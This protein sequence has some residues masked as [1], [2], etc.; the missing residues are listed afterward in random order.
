MLYDNKY[1][2]LTVQKSRYFTEFACKGFICNGF[3][4][5]NELVS[6]RITGFK[7]S[8]S[9]SII[10]FSCKKKKPYNKQLNNLV[11]SVVT[12]ESQTSA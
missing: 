4:L 1:T 6:A 12:E 2:F 5:V 10:F 11:R 8:T 7:M 3:E 9:A